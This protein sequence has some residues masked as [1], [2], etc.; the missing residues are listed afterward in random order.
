MQKVIS[1]YNGN[2]L[3]VAL[4]EVRVRQVACAELLALLLAEDGALYSLPYDTLQLQP[5]LGITL[6]PY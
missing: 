5:I 3:P 4:G 6:H 1:L 2:I